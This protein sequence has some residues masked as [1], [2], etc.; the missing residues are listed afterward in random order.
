MQGC[1]CCTQLFGGGIERLRLGSAIGSRKVQV[2]GPIDRYY[3]EMHVGNLKAGSHQTYLFG[4][5]NCHLSPANLFGD[6]QQMLQ[7]AVGKI[8]PVVDF[9]AGH[10]KRVATHCSS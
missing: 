6:S 10:N 3:V 1:Q 7:K 2:M 5:E 4:A 8:E 9:L